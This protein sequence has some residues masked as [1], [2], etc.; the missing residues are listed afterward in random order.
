MLSMINV[1]HLSNQY[2]Y[3][4]HK[5]IFPINFEGLWNVQFV[6]IS[7]I[8][9]KDRYLQN[10]WFGDIWMPF[11]QLEFT[12]VIILSLRIAYEALIFLPHIWVKNTD[13]LLIATHFII[14]DWQ[15][16]ETR[17]KVCHTVLSKTPFE[18]SLFGVF[19]GLQWPWP[20]GCNVL[21]HIMGKTPKN[22]I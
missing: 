21:W 19:S 16:L 14:L 6:S 10:K 9:I 20:H 8:T 5:G 7:A 15:V 2:V 3:H 13:P 12:S 18:S 1:C 4:E 17:P 22:L 11:K